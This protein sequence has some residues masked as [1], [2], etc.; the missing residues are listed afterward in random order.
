MTGTTRNLT[1][2]KCNLTRH[3]YHD[4]SNVIED[5]LD[6]AAANQCPPS[7]ENSRKVR[8]GP[9]GGVA[10]P[11]PVKLHQLLEEGKHS[12]IIS[13][14]PHGRCFILRKPHE[15]LI[16]VMT[17]YF[18]QTKL[19]SFQRQLNLYA[20]KRIS[21]GPDKG[22]YYHELFLRGKVK[23]CTH[24]I[25]M[26]VK[27]TK[28]K[29]ASCPESE[30]NFYAMPALKESPSCDAEPISE[31]DTISFQQTDFLQ[32]TNSKI[33]ASNRSTT[34]SLISD[35]C[36]SGSVMTSSSSSE[37]IQ[38]FGPGAGPSNTK[39]FSFPQSPILPPVKV[40]T[41]LFAP[42]SQSPFQHHQ[43]SM[44]SPEPKAVTFEGKGFYYLDPFDH[45]DACTLP[46]GDQCTSDLVGL[47]TDPFSGE[48]C[49]F[50]M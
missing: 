7:P 41:R 43:A 27:G 30:P 31:D 8:R 16:K 29:S 26:R 44:T 42:S 18:K 49:G 40:V 17:K 47:S 14:Q 4:Y 35:D 37:Q 50:E 12:D 48:L 1:M 5:K 36:S 46:L 23:L 6:D 2:N 24:M 11:F 20:F 21:S 34:G 39:T 32:N 13:W 45:W 15:F 9:R 33:D 22:A 10:T 38:G 19:T 28:I 25:R 3:Q